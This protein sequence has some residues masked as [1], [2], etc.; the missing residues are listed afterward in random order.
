M[1][2]VLHKP[3]GIL[4]Q[5]TPELNSQWKTLQEFV[6]PKH[7]YPVGRLDADSE[8]MLVLTDERKI[9]DQLL[10]PAHGHA[11]TYWVQVEHD[12][13]NE[14][15]DRLS[16]G[17]V[18]QGRRTLPCQA[19]IIDPKPCIYE[20]VP[21]IRTRKAITTSWIELVLTEGRNRQVRKMTAAVGNPTLRLIRVQV[22]ALCLFDLTI[23]A[24]QW[25]ELDTAQR[26]LLLQ[27]SD[28]SKD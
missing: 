18:I 21:P 20:R 8:G 1:I 4:S 22:G 5:F 9:V 23:S 15:L 25:C 13:T 24:G 27:S 16:S 17:V 2:L 19:R 7:V 12:V 14:S 3:Y 6:L 11:R 10:S 26:R 28:R